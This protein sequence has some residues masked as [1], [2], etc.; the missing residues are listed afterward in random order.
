MPLTKQDRAPKIRGRK[1]TKKSARRNV[2]E[3]VVLPTYSRKPLPKDGPC[4]KVTCRK[5]SCTAHCKEPATTEGAGAYRH[6]VDIEWLG[7]AK[8]YRDG[9]FDVS[10]VN[11]GEAG[12]VK[13][14]PETK[15]VAWG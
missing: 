5:E 7:W 10:C 14:V 12:W 11:C 2:K 9:T 13:H 1:T 3:P 4:P 8:G 15:D 6:E